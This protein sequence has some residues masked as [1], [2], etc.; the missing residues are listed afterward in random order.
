ML[1]A[2]ANYMCC[3]PDCC[4]PTTLPLESPT[5]YAKIGNAAH[6]KGQTPASMRYDAAQTNKERGSAENGIHLCANCHAIIDT[7]TATE[8]TVELLQGWKRAR[9]ELIRSQVFRIKQNDTH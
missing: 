2:R 8:Y 3:N 9:E 5:A 1:A 6:I 4:I 7:S